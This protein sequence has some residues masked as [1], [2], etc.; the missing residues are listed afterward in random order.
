MVT[1]AYFG[2]GGAMDAFLVAFRLPNMLRRLFAEG[3][4]TVAFVPVFIEVLEKDGEEAANRLGRISFTF[5][6]LV[7][8]V[9]SLIGVLAAPFLVKLMAWGF[10]KDPE[11]FALTVDLTRLIFPYIALIGLT[12]LAGGMLNARGVFSYPALAPV[13]LNLFIIS[14]VVLFAGRLATPV[15]SLA[16]GVMVGGVFQLAMQLPPLKKLGFKLYPDFHLMDPFVRRILKLM[17]PSVLGVAVYQINILVSTFLASWLPDGSVSY[18]YYADRLFQLPLG[19]FAVSLGTASLPSFSRLAARGETEALR[20]SFVN[21]MRMSTFVVLPAAVGLI[22]LSKPILTVLFRRGAFTPSMVDATSQAL[23]CYSF[24]LLPVAWTRV[25]APAFYAIKDMTTPVRAAFWSLFV[26]LAASLVLMGPMKHSGLALATSI[27]SVFNLVY[28]LLNLDRRV[29]GL[30]LG[31]IWTPVIKMFGASMIMA[32]FVFLVSNRI[33]WTGGPIKL[34][35]I[36]FPLIL[37]G[38][39]I[40]ILLTRAMGMKDALAVSGMLSRLVGRR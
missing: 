24:A 36:L 30:H 40:Y 31:G 23:I 9:I 32:V 22:V 4:L 38:V 25:A 39:G 17:G 29:G 19:V 20:E 8:C 18:L 12:A 16:Y 35:F 6:A 3:S 5:L 21:A 37:S 27:S 26:N 7:L 33:Q 34:S 13:V 11:K 10:Y 28:L 15:Q 14:I 2:S 1:A